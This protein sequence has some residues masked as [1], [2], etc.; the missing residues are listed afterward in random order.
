MMMTMLLCT[1]E[2]G[3]VLAMRRADASSIPDAGP[4]H[5]RL[6]QYKNSA[7]LPNG[8]RTDFASTPLPSRKVAGYNTGAKQMDAILCFCCLPCN[9]ID[10]RSAPKP[11]TKQ[12]RNMKTTT[13]KMTMMTTTMGEKT[14]T[15][16]RMSKSAS[17]SSRTMNFHSNLATPPPTYPQQPRNFWAE[18]IM[19][20]TATRGKVLHT[21]AQTYRSPYWF[22]GVSS[23]GAAGTAF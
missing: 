1:C 7:T 22:A 19:P 14:R 21:P 23:Y 16:K 15:K 18:N 13:T 10:P 12:N 5:T 20:A 8:N 6:H 11:R 17:S 9:I 3:S 4:S 2:S